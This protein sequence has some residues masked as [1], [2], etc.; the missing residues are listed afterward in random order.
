M[1]TLLVVAVFVAGFALSAC[2]DDAKT[3]TIVQDRTTTVTQ[4]E[5]V[6]ATTPAKPEHYEFFQSPSGNIGCA[7]FEQEVVQ[8]RCD[9]REHSWDSPPKPADCD[10][11]YGSG[12]VIEAGGKAEFVCAGDTTLNSGP[13]LKYGEVNKVG[14]ISCTSSEAGMRCVDEES[15]RGFFL[16]R[17]RYEIF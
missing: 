15:G 17:E 3:T 10:V 6:Q 5:T 12:L 2:G 11:D 7:G 4:T 8:I 9:I 1:R 16:A 14:L 13:T